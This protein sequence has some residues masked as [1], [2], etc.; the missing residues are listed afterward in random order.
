ME[1]INQE[2]KIAEKWFAF[3]YFYMDRFN[4]NL[5]GRICITICLLYF[6]VI[7][8]FLDHFSG[9]NKWIKVSIILIFSF[10]F[11]SNLPDPAAIYEEE[12][13]KYLERAKYV[14][15]DP[16][17]YVSHPPSVREFFV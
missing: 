9:I 10:I 8:I 13:K 16:E 4:R 6:A 11:I 3:E 2:V 14:N 15:W 12:Q 17:R 1:T 5:F 7:M